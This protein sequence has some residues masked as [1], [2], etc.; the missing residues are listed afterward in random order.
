MGSRPLLRGYHRRL[1]VRARRAR[2]EGPGRRQPRRVPRH[3]ARADL[4][5]TRDV[6]FCAFADEEEGGTFG[7]EWV[8]NNHQDLIDAEFA[9]NEGGG[10]PLTIAGVE[11][12]SCQVAEKG[13]ARLKL[14]AHGTPG[15]ASVP[16]PDT[17]FRNLGIALERL[18]AWE[19]PTVIVPADAG[20]ARKHR[21][22]CSAASRCDLIA[23]ALATDPPTWE[24]LVEAPAHATTSVARSTPAPGTPW[25]RR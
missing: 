24:P 18:H 7:A 10:E 21:R 20:H 22:R 19:P 16:L 14:T 5:L 8:W 13:S 4:P 1:R 15:H 17:A 9:I 6:I 3:Q 23:E 11:F 12:I 2:H 25:C